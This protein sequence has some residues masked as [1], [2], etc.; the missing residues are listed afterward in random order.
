M[1]VFL[2]RASLLSLCVFVFINESGGF[3]SKTACNLNTALPEREREREADKRSRCKPPH[4]LALKTPI[5]W[6]ICSIFNKCDYC[7]LLLTL[8][9]F[10][11]VFIGREVLIQGGL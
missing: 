3:N 8:E 7:W 1:G 4:D 11:R 2:I 6:T 9:Q 5:S 10:N